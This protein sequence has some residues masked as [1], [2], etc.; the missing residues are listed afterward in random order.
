MHVQNLVNSNRQ[1]CRTGAIQTATYDVCQHVETCL[2]V[3]AIRKLSFS[4]DGVS[5]GTGQSGLGML[6]A[7]C[8]GV[9]CIALL[10]VTSSMKHL[11]S[12]RRLHSNSATSGMPGP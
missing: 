10:T 1:V 7:G 3:H 2:I 6:L 8:A 4:A 11:Y 12:E 9:S 5:S